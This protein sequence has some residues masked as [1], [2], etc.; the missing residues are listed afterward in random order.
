[1]SQVQQ[2][3]PGPPPSLSVAKARLAE[4]GN[5]IEPSALRFQVGQ[6]YR[7]REDFYTI[8][9]AICLL[10]QIESLNLVSP[11]RKQLFDECLNACESWTDFAFHSRDGTNFDG[12]TFDALE[13]RFRCSCG[14]LFSSVMDT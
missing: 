8:S 3:S 1:M 13:K 9:L 2:P 14:S 10:D 5:L 4:L 7:V 11:Q 6:S 12:I